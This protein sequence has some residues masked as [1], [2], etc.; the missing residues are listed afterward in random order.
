[1]EDQHS[2]F[3]HLKSWIGFLKEQFESLEKLKI[4]V[5]RIFC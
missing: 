1:M 4:N 2:N 5:F 3:S